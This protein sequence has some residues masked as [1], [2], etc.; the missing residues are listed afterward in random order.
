MIDSHINLNNYMLEKMGE[1]NEI[2]DRFTRS[3]LLFGENFERMQNTSVIILGVGGVGSY[4]LDCL[5]RSGIGDITIVDNDVFEV[6]NQNRQIG[7]DRIGEPKVAVLADMYPGVKAL[8]ECVDES[9]LEKINIMKYDYIVDAIDDINA[10][11]NI[12]NIAQSK[13]YGKFI[14]STGSAKKL[15][16]LCI[17]VDSIW[18]TYGDKF[19]RKYRDHLKKAHISKGFK[20]IFSPEVPKCKFLGSF[21]AVT[22][23]FGLIIAGE[24]IKDIV[25]KGHITTRE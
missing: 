21:S 14:V 2:I 22:A 3:R 9:F 16:P 17:K 1:S 19:A 10:K 18:K 7:S 23:S 12:A 4:A 24:V 8:Q 25:N 13:P 6:T 11:V 5:Y 20:A 15:N